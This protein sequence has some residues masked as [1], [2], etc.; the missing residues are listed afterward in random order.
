MKFSKVDLQQILSEIRELPAQALDEQ[1]AKVVEALPHCVA[2]LQATDPQELNEKTLAPIIKHQ[3]FFLDFA[4]LVLGISQDAFATHA[5]ELLT[6]GNR[7]RVTWN[8]LETMSKKDAPAL[9]KL[10]AGMRFPSAAEA[11]VNRQ[12]SAVEV[13]EDRYKQGRGRAIAGI[14]RGSF[15][16]KEVA[17]ILRTVGAPIDSGVNYKGFKGLQAKCD[18]AV[19]GIAE[20]ATCRNWWS[21]TLTVR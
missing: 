15:L 10:L 12:W 14:T 1:G 11:V 16:E 6:G 3:P 2:A 7:R 5:S 9:A 19:P 4:R 20:P 21:S 17:S 13:L 8:Q 18:F